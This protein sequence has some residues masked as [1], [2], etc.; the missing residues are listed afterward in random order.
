MTLLPYG[1]GVAEGLLDWSK[2]TCCMCGFGHR[3]F[4]VVQIDS[5]D[6]QTDPRFGYTETAVCQDCFAKYGW[7]PALNHNVDIREQQELPPIPV[8]APPTEAHLALL[9]ERD[10]LRDELL[11]GLEK[12]ARKDGFT[13][14]KDH[15]PDPSL[16]T[17][18][19][20]P[21]IAH[22]LRRLAEYGRFRIVGEA[23]DSVSGYWP[24]DDPEKK[25]SE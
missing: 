4:I 8:C 22:A 18:L 24:E 9:K 7:E 25:E 23:G 3:A 17:S 12:L 5:P 20:K 10:E 13:F 16:T 11:E 2:K 14:S 6:P 19:R 1:P 21:T 15:A